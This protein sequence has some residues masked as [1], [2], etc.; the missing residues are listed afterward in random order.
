MLASG[1]FTSSVSEP[2][3]SFMQLPLSNKGAQERSWYDFMLD[4]MTAGGVIKRVDLDTEIKNRFEIRMKNAR[5]YYAVVD[6]LILYSNAQFVSSVDA[7]KKK[8]ILSGR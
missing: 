7:R 3:A 8:F 4:C 2:V 5:A 1:W 6:L